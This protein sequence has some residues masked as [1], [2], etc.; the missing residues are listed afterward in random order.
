MNRRKFLTGTA[1]GAGAALLGPH[2]FGSV[3]DAPLAVPTQT[4]K[5]TDMVTL[6]KTGI[7]TS[8][9][10]MG[11]GTI[12][13][14]GA[15]N[16]TRTNKLPQLLLT[17]YD[18]GLRFFDTAD[19]YG[20]H[21]DVA[22]AL[23]HIPREKVVVMTKC[24]SRDPAQAK[25]DLERFRKELG[26]EYIDICLMHCLTEDD[27]TS[28]YQGVMDVFSEAKAKGH[29]R[30]HGVSCHTL[31]ALRAAAKSPWVEVDLVRLNPVGAHMDAHPDTVIEVV[32]EMRASG[33]GIVGM[34]ILGQGAMRTRQDEAL[35]FALGTGVLDAFTIG[36]EN[37]AEQHDLMQRIATV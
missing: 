17:G 15:S 16:Q 22:E 5:A 27:W 29:I 3:L 12:G 21:P 37:A 20:S 6:G 31:G 18:R 33:K 32:K 1:L 2:S 4:F 11:T 14:G 19:S 36:A 24:D 34:K 30:A 9:L 8:R 23:K 10:A 13:G 35:R 26:T 28:R 25:A 7:R